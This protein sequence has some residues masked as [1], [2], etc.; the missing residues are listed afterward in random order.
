MIVEVKKNGQIYR[1]EYKNGGNPV[2]PLENGLLP[3]V[4]KCAKSASGTKAVL[5]PVT[6]VPPST[7]LMRLQYGLICSEK[8]EVY[9]KATSTSI[10]PLLPSI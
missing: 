3:A 9:W 8:L 7:T 4:G 10:S 2:I 5:K 6:K 1:D